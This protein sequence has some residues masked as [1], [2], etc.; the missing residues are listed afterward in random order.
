MPYG[1]ENETPEITKWM[2]RCVQAVQKKNNKLDKSSAIAICKYQ[3]KKSKDDTE[4]AE[5][6]LSKLLEEDKYR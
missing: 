4:K 3:L 2:E 6:Y 1:I 5:F